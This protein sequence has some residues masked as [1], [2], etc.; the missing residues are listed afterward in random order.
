[1]GIV[2]KI[3]I[4]VLVVLVLLACPVF[5]TLATVAPNYKAL[6]IAEKAKSQDN[7]VAA[8]HAKLAA[9]HADMQRKDI[10]DKAQE[11]STAG[12]IELDRISAALQDAR[13]SS[14]TAQ[15]DLMLFKAE[16]Q[17]LRA[18]YELNSARTEDLDAKWKDSIAAVEDLSEENR[19][20]AQDLKRAQLEYERVE[21]VARA[22][23]E[24]LVASE[25]QLRRA[26]SGGMETSS[27][28]QADAMVTSDVKITGTVQ[29]VRGDLASVNVGSAKGVTPGMKMIIY[30]GANLVGFLRV[31]T[32]DVGES[33]GIIFDRRLNPMQ[34]DKVTTDLN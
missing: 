1:M 28:S 20:L 13:K 10:S 21:N 30:R 7:A 22:R 11:K 8:R 6:Y 27:A 9:Q 23:H 3:S 32:V 29:T 18:D 15:N 26:R 14:L 19:Q 31:E 16:L 5:I 17:K 24:Q 4:V 34:G 12:Q 25:E 33:A 2:T